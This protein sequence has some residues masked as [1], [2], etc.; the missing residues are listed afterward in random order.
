MFQ[1]KLFYKQLFCIF[2][3]LVTLFDPSSVEIKQVQAVPTFETY[4]KQLSFQERSEIQKAM[5]SAAGS[6]EKLS[7]SEWQ[8]YLWLH[9]KLAEQQELKTA[10]RAVTDLL[11]VGIS[12]QLSVNS[13]AAS[14][15]KAIIGTNK[16]P[17][18]DVLVYGNEVPAVAAAVS[19]A[20]GMNGKGNI[21]LVRSEL[22]TEPFGGLINQGGLAYLDRNQ[23]STYLPPSSEFYREFL[24]K[25]KVIHASLDPNAA[26]GALQAML[27]EAGVKIISGAK[28][29]A[30]I[31]DKK[32]YSLSVQDS[33]EQIRARLYID[34]TENAEL[35]RAAG[36]KY[37][38]GFE[39]LGFPQS[40]LPVSPVFRVTGL[41]PL[42]LLKLEEEVL[43]NPIVMQKIREKIKLELEPKYADWL[44]ANSDKPLYIGPDYI[45]IRSIGLGAAYHYHRDKPYDLKAGFLFDKANIAILKDGSLSWNAFLYKLPSDKVMELVNTG[46]KPTEAMLAE[47]KAFE[48]WLHTFPQGKKAKI[49]PPK[50]LYIR[51]SLNITD[52]VDQLT[53]KEIIRGGT[54]P[55]NSV[56]T[57]CYFFDV[58]G[59]LDGMSGKMPKP[60]FNF[61]IE[62]SLTNIQNLAVVGRSAG[63]AGLAPAVGRILELNVSVGS[64]VG[65]AAALAVK[66][67]SVFNTITSAQARNAV[68][69]QT[70]LKVILGGKDL[71]KGID[72]KII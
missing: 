59:G 61:G 11:Q 50:E 25:A 33:D 36:L 48:D 19:A 49:I 62:H 34:A 69:K 7:S 65:A 46:S 67:G 32:I 53:G 63:Y 12:H 20:R 13:F 21:V 42:E 64:Y 15:L 47:L 68:E 39:S 41:S 70:G 31:I 16:T 27:A 22:P 40:T 29:E 5:Y 55:V 35:A 58:R 8:A 3:Q 45:D 51:H 1:L 38:I 10:H 26:N 57:F 9:P 60:V 66:N 30:N 52:V 4:F 2:V 72:E 37:S 14:N 56:G 28:L 71:S 44:L 43:K 18:Y 54:N 23:L 24:N 17:V 6:D